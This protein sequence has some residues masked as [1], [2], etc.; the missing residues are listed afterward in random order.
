MLR[1]LIEQA[2]GARLLVLAIAATVAAAGVWAF[3]TLPVDA[4]P[5]IAATQ[6]KV[7]LKAPGMTPEEVA[8]RLAA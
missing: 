4:Y 1:K 5:N 2:L 6:V 8:A 7:I 3:T